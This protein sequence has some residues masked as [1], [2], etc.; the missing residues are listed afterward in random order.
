MLEPVSFTSFFLKYLLL[1]LGG[2]PFFLFEFSLL[3]S[4]FSEASMEWLPRNM[5]NSWPTSCWWRGRG[6]STSQLPPGK[7]R[8]WSYLTVGKGW[9][10]GKIFCYTGCFQIRLREAGQGEL[11]H[12]HHSSCKTQ[13]LDPNTLL[14]LREKLRHCSQLWVRI[15]CRRGWQFGKELGRENGDTLGHRWYLTLK[16]W[17]CHLNSFME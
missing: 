11:L 12:W 14:F 13:G 6:S 9:G 2:N 3:P 10:E 7:G 5:G 16:A 17:S 4:A 8:S 1:S 15:S